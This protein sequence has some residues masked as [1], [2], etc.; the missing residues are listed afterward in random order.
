M[1]TADCATEG[2]CAAATRCLTMMRAGNRA[3]DSGDVMTLRFRLPRWWLRGFGVLFAGCA[4]V[5]Q[6]HGYEPEVGT[7]I[8]EFPIVHANGQPLDWRP[9]GASFRILIIGASWCEPCKELKASLPDELARLRQ[10]GINVST[11]YVQADGFGPG[12]G[13]ATSPSLTSNRHGYVEAI[14]DPRRIDLTKESPKGVRQWGG[15][16]AYGYPTTIL[17]DNRNVVVERY[18][19]SPRTVMGDVVA[20]ANKAG[21]TARTPIE[22][23]ATVVA[24]RPERVLAPPTRAAARDRSDEQAGDELIGLWKINNPEAKDPRPLFLRVIGVNATPEG[25]LELEASLSYKLTEWRPLP[26][27]ARCEPARAHC[28]LRLTTR[29]RSE[30]TATRQ[31]D[32]TYTG[33]IVIPARPRTLVRPITMEPMS[34]DDAEL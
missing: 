27:P 15:F 18:R 10:H 1:P 13:G 8:N 24:P 21:A 11:I 16:R 2:V 26:A 5:H 25:P 12:A 31:P 3:S 4:F 6:S 23:P 20:L 19:G 34:L 29:S 9:D 14:P 7:A 17:L 22:L 32:G 30:L 33:T 28:V